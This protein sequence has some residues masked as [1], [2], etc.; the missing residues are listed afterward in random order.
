MTTDP[1][2]DRMLKDFLEAGK[3]EVR[4]LWDRISDDDKAIAKSTIHH[5]ARI[6]LAALQGEDVTGDMRD[7]KAQ[8][9][10]LKAATAIEVRKALLA[11]FGRSVDILK[12]MAA[13]LGA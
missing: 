3:D 5:L 2:F 4:T 1:L 10:N 12:K 9:A 8:L 6:K 13:G 7:I 11:V